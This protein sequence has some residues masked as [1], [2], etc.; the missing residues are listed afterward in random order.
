ML[1]S[2]RLLRQELRSLRLLRRDLWLLRR[3]L[4]SLRLRWRELR[5]LRLLR[6]ELRR[7]R[8]RRRR[9]GVRVGAPRLR[10]GRQLGAQGEDRLVARIRLAKAPHELLELTI[11]AS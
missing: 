7:L 1:Q 5:S 9:R 4:R 6:R 11:R 10:S 8:L 2:L 3:E